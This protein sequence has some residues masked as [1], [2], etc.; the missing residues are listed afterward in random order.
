MKMTTET[1]IHTAAQRRLDNATRYLIKANKQAERYIAMGCRPYSRDKK[2]TVYR[3]N[4]PYPL[5][6]ARAMAVAATVNI[7]AAILHTLGSHVYN[8]HHA[9]GMAK[10]A[11]VPEC[12]RDALA[13]AL[14]LHSVVSEAVTEMTTAIKVEHRGRMH[15]KT[16]AAH[17]AIVR[18]L[19]MIDERDNDAL[20]DVGGAI[21]RQY[22]IAIDREIMEGKA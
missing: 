18:G 3:R 9:V 10:N 12:R 14:S 17:D 5:E 20:F 16:H 1:A 7:E 4:N 11:R 15:A 6:K 8:T 22:A 19:D 2:E 13:F 21:I